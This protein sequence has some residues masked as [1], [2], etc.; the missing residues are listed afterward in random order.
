MM[1]MPP[2]H[3]VMERQNR[4]AWSWLEMSAITLDPVVVNPDI[5]SK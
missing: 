3:C 4:I 5:D 2:S 1:P